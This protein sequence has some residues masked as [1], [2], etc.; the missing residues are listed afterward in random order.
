MDGNSIEIISVRLATLILTKI[1]FKTNDI[2]LLK[3]RGMFH[4]N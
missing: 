2:A 1:D 3:R 4:N